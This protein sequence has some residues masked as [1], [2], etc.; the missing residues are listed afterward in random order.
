MSN[1]DKPRLDIR[2][3]KVLWGIQFRLVSVDFVRL[4]K[5][6]GELEVG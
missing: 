6:V 4:N 1:T 3:P 5:V 2:G